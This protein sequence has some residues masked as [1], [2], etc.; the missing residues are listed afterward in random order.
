M[1]MH[2]VAP[3][4]GVRDVAA[5]LAHY[6]KLGF[7]TR[8]YDSGYGYVNRDAVEIH[9]GGVGAHSATTT[10][11]AYIW[12]DDA[13]ALAD[14]WRAAGIDVDEPVDTEWGMHEG[15]LVDPDGN[16]IRFGSPMRH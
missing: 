14:E 3:I 9:L 10:S 6:Q 16:V 5:S 12:V 7:T 13:D 8:E 11:S 4:F 2:R 15:S 1:T